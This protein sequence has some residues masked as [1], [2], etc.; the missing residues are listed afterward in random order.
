MIFLDDEDKPLLPPL[1]EL[2]CSV[3]V[4]TI[5]A[6]PVVLARTSDEVDVTELTA[7][8]APVVTMTVETRCVDETTSA[9]V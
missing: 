6:K 7:P 9:D 2:A 5:V 8:S 1:S 3:G 4:V